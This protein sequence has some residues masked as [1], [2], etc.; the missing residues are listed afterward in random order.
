MW[1]SGQNKAVY[2]TYS[3]RSGIRMEYCQSFPLPAGLFPMP[4]EIRF[5]AYG[6]FVTRKCLSTNHAGAIAGTNTS[7]I[8]S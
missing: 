1:I 5:H 4:M 7:E 3:H 8:G 6:T 2:V